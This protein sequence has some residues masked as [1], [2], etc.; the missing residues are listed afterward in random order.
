MK[1]STKFWIGTGAVVTAASAAAVASHAVTKYLMSM[2]LDRKKPE[3]ILNTEKAGDYLRGAPYLE[4]FLHAISV[5]AE[6]LKNTPTERV[7]IQ[8]R[9]GIQL[10][11]H[12]RTCPNSRRIILAM[13]G[14]RSS[15]D[16]DFGMIADFWY[17]HNCTVLYAEQ[18]GQNDSGGDYM[19]FGMLERFDCLDWVNWLN[20]R[21]P[22][23]MPT[24][25][26][27]VSM[28]ASTVLMASNL[29]L[30][31]NVKGIAADCGLRDPE[32]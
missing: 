26:A 9:D 4:S 16:Q 6:K 32:I 7:Q 3:S 13:H 21:F 20:E 27:G 15:W 8:S 18:R 10:V 12:L 30:P 25:L 5:D 29:D 22:E 17:E 23:K 24:Y 31:D 11:G 19:G 2:A 1:K 28:G 14:W